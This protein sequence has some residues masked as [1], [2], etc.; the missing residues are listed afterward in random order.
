MLFILQSHYFA[1][2]NGESTTEFYVR[3]QEFLKKVTKESVLIDE[4]L[5]NILIVAH[6]G[7]IHQLLPAM[8]AEIKTEV[9]ENIDLKN[10]LKKNTAYLI[11][12]MEVS[13]NDFAISSVECEKA[14]SAAHLENLEI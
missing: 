10:G 2:K 3:V 8:F 6:G 7:S 11:M 14:C 12:K 4:N 1:S 5:P 9:Q 13:I